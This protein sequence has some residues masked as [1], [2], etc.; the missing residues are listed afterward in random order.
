MYK[1]I[2]KKINFLLDKL[3]LRITLGDSLLQIYSTECE[4]RKVL[5]VNKVLLPTYIQEKIIQILPISHSYP[6]LQ[7]F[8]SKDYQH[9][10]YE[11]VKLL[12][13]SDPFF[14]YDIIETL[15]KMGTYQFIEEIRPFSTLSMD[16]KMPFSQ[17][18]Y[19]I[20][21][22]FYSKFP[23]D[24]F[25]QRYHKCNQTWEFYSKNPPNADSNFKW[26]NN[27]ANQYIKRAEKLKIKYAT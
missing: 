17:D 22:E 16:D 4:L 18:S 6:L 25:F 3:L 13:L 1:K 20:G 9:L 2:E 12:D 27:I 7:V 21:L 11:V 24:W 15:Y 5:E 23:P 19:R 26:I 8:Q 10:S 14:S